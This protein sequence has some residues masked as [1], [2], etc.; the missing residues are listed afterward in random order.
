[1]AAT[2]IEVSPRAGRRVGVVL[3][4][5]FIAATAS[6]GFRT[7]DTGHV[8]VTTLFGRLTGEQLSE[9]LHVVNP[10]KRVEEMSIRTLEIKEHADVPS[11]EG[12]I[13]GL[14]TSL[15]YRLEPERA[16]EVYQKIGPRYQEIVVIPNLR[17]VMRAVTAA[18]TAN[19]LY[20]E[21]REQV[22]QQM[23]EQLKK[24]LDARGV[25]VENVLL[26]DIRLPDTLRTAIESKQQADQQSQ[27]MQFVLQREPGGGAQAHRG[28]RRQRFPAHRLAGHQRAAARVEG[29]RGHRE[30]RQQP[31]QQDRGHRQPKERPAAHSRPVVVTPLPRLAR[32]S[33]TPRAIGGRGVTSGYHFTRTR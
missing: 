27:Q 3:L 29:H 31:E 16:A 9:G 17:S 15:L 2:T 5:A 10:L 25:T 23:L 21:G 4:L 26:R 22:A 8:G 13:I 18:H 33:R 32:S 24:I 11:S 30:A 7:I 6:C 12:L 28:A 20:S 14:E 19:A 1:M